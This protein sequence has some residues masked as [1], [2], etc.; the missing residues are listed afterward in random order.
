M[1]VNRI[2]KQTRQYQLDGVISVIDVEN[3]RGYEDTSFTAKL[4]AQYTDLLVLNKWELVS[5]RVLEDCIDHILDLDL[6]IPT[7]RTKSHKGLVDK[8][9]LLGLD[10]KLIQTRGPEQ[11]G[12][13]RN[14]GHSGEHHSEVEVLSVKLSSTSRIDGVNLEKLEDLLTNVNKGEV[15]RIKAVIWALSAP[16]SSTGEPAEP[17]PVPGEAHRYILNWAFGRWLF[18]AVPTNNQT[19]AGFHA[20]DEPILRM[21]IITGRDES[22][23]W[24]ERLGEFIALENDNCTV[25][26]TRVS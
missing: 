23:K 6:E 8:N 4:Q 26:V 13:L 12:Y 22:E 15:Y 14:H 21:T 24:S 11:P 18:T 7:P 2:S 16:S 3:W 20:D 9:L 1:E 25:E 17:P 19:I 10:A 5:E